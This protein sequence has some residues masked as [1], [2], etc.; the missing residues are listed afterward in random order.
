MKTLK[1]EK[2]RREKYMPVTGQTFWADKWE[3]ENAFNCSD[4]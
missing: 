4:N 1:K 2:K 3:W